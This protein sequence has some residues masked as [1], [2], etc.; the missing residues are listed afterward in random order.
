MS[1]SIDST[2]TLNNRTAQYPEPAIEP[3]SERELEVL[4]WLASGTPNR[5]IGQRLYIRHYID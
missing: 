1:K 2:Q 4:Q 5:E 3:L